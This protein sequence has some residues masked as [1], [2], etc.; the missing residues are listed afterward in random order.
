MRS[1]ERSRL[2]QNWQTLETWGCVRSLTSPRRDRKIAIVDGVRYDAESLSE[3]EASEIR[4]DGWALIRSE[5][6]TDVENRN[7]GTLR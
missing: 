6:V 7:Q 4:K 2:Y 5:S 1:I 3:V